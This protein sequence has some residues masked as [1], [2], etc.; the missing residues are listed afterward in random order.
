[1]KS[2]KM[3]LTLLVIAT[4]CGVYPLC[5]SAKDPV[6]TPQE[7]AGELANWREKCNDPDPDL[8]LAYIESAIASNDY[9]IQRICMRS[10]LESNDSDLR[11]IGLRGAIA[12]MGQIVVDISMPEELKSALDKAKGDENKLKD[13]HGTYL[14][15]YYR[16]NAAGIIMLIDQKS[17]GKSVQKWYCL[18]NV[19]K[20]SDEYSGTANLGGGKILWSGKM[21][22][23]SNSSSTGTLNL[24]VDSG[25]MA[26]GFFQVGDFAPFPASGKLY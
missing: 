22:N 23:T 1:M 13:I 19:T 26:K 4:V 16:S 24:T 10:A 21:R 9:S 7:R 3:Y 18:A 14:Y 6:L 25:G 12:S 17:T 5:A 20:P 2:L 15:R 11:E 8:R